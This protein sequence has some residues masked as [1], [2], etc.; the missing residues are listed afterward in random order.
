MNRAKILE[1]YRVDHTG[2]IKSSGKFECEFLYMPHFF[3][4]YLNGCSSPDADDEMIVHI[5]IQPEDLEEFPELLKG[6]DPYKAGDTIGL[7]FYENGFVVE[8]NR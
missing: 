4:A 1:S 7:I 6:N 5:E 2:V 8:L 3:E